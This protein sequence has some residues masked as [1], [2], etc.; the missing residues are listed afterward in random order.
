M[1]GEILKAVSEETKA[2]LQK[3]NDG[4]FPGTVILETDFKSDQ[5]ASYGMPLVILDMMDAPDM[6]QYIGGSTRADWIFGMNSYNYQ[7]DGYLDDG[8]DYSA[9]LLNIIDDIRRH[10]SNRFWIRDARADD[11]TPMTMP[12]IEEVYGF[13]FT[14]SGLTR[15]N[16][17]ER[18]GMVMG[19]R[20]V[21]DSLSIDEETDN[22]YPSPEPMEGVDPEGYP[23]D[24]EPNE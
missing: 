10:F 5:M 8:T 13:K 15:A 11:S 3:S 19:W 6:S 22:V 21:F 12:D 9:N 7:P 16:A 24:W 20:I 2:F 4:N 1:T 17:L 14:L 18:D 23:E